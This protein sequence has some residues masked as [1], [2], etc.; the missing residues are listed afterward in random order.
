MNL[1][2]QTVSSRILNLRHVVVGYEEVDIGIRTLDNQDTLGI[3]ATCSTDSLDESLLIL[4]NTA[5]HFSHAND[6]TIT[7]SHARLIHTGKEKMLIVCLEVVG[8]LSP[9]FGKLSLGS[10]DV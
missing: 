5:T 1:Y 3:V 9:D 7:C 8:N 2:H 6:I 10:L 4:S